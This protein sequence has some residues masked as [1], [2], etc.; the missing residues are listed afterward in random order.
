MHSQN[1]HI[2]ELHCN[3]QFTFLSL[4]LNWKLLEVQAQFYSLLFPQ[5]LA[6]LYTQKTINE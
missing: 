3:Y 6:V 4:L 5:D 1:K 2:D